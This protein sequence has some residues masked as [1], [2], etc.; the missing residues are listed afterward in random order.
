MQAKTLNKKTSLLAPNYSPPRPS[1]F[2]KT[3]VVE[4]KLK[5]TPMRKMVVCHRSFSLPPQEKREKKGGGK[6]NKECLLGEKYVSLLKS[7]SRK[8]G[9]V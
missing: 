7:W 3:G 1:F 8:G 4:N 5:G 2:S 9:K 6:G